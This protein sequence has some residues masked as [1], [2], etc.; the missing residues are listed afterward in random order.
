MLSASTAPAFPGF[1]SHCRGSLS[2]GR[3]TER[4]GR[5]AGVGVL[6]SATTA[7]I[8]SMASNGSTVVSFS[9]ER[10]VVLE[11]QIVGNRRPE[12]LEDP[13]VPLDDQPGVLLAQLVVAVGGKLVHARS[14]RASSPSLNFS[15]ALGKSPVL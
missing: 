5:A 3:R 6:A 14:S 7:P 15:A 8:I 2:G 4:R 11:R 1:G 12:L 10:Q 9:T 13:D